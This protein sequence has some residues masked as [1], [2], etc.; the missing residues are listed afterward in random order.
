MSLA[1][2][3]ILVPE[4]RELD[5]FAGMLEKQGA[6]TIRCPMVAIRDVDDAGPVR[7][8][9]GRLAAGLHDDLVLFTGE[10]VTR[11]IECAKR[12][13]MEPEVRQGFARVRI[14]VRGPKPTRA[15]RVIG[16]A[17][18]LTAEAPT[19]EGLIAT[20]SR[21]DL[22]GR[23]VGVQ[24]YPGSP[25][26]LLDFL[27]QAGATADP[28]LPY[29]YASKEDDSRV[30]DAIRALAAGEIDLVAFTSTPQIR[31]FQEVAREAGLEAQLGR[32]MGATRIAAV[33]PVTAEAVAKAGW[34]ATIV[35]QESFH[36]K[37]LVA[38]I[39]AAFRGDGAPAATARP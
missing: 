28:V 7:A 5:L 9:L 16:L 30:A 37:P 6:E 10:G 4:T 25:N 19:T 32:G 22:S 17:P 21:L 8:W 36:L 29:Q 20:L 39:A 38:E 1:G 2:R 31:R 26:T 14:L 15:L 18:S 34:S 23:R 35:P 33:G 3:R 11:L 24:T 12:A 13:G 27:A